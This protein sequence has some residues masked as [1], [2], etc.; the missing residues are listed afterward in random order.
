MANLVIREDLCKGC[1][2]CVEVCPRGVL[3]PSKRPSSWGL[4]LAEV[5]RPEA[6]ILC[7]LCEFYCP[8]MAVEVRG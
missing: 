4:P 2:I 3:A 5:A 1:G 6:C 7:R 8:D